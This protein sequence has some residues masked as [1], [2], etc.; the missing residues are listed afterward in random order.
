M[1]NQQIQYF[2]LLYTRFPVA[3]SVSNRLHNQE[4]SFTTSKF[5]NSSGTRQQAGQYK[6]TCSKI[7]RPKQWYDKLIRVKKLFFFGRGVHVWCLT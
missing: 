1:T 2:M 6:S 5:T 7:R 3:S 4:A